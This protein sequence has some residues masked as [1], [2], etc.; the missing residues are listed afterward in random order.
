MT[1]KKLYLMILI[2][3]CASIKLSHA[4][5]SQSLNGGT[6]Q[7]MMSTAETIEAGF[8]TWFMNTRVD[9]FNSATTSG[10][11]AAQIKINLGYVVALGE[12]VEWGF[13]APIIHYTP[14]SLSATP[15][16]SGEGSIRTTFKYNFLKPTGINSSSKA[17][18][19]FSSLSPE[20]S[21]AE[22]SSKNDLYGI[23]YN[24]SHY[25]DGIA[26]HTNFGYKRDEVYSGTVITP[27][28]DANFIT[29]SI[30]L[31]RVL[32][33]ITTMSIQGLAEV[34]D[35][36]R[37]KNLLLS[38]S[39]LYSLSNNVALT[40]G[41]LIGVPDNRSNPNNSIFF[42]ISYS[43]GKES[44]PQKESY[45]YSI[46]SNPEQ[47]NVKRQEELIEKIST[48]EQRLANIEEWLTKQE[49]VSVRSDSLMSV[50]AHKDSSKTKESSLEAK[51]KRLNIEIIVPV[52]RP[53]YNDHIIS[54][55]KNDKY[56]FIQKKVKNLVNK[57]SYIF[58]RSGLRKEAISLGHSLDGNQTVLKKTLPKGVDLQI[59][60]GLDLLK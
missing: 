17:V 16:L 3:M 56:R 6:G 33:D 7:G 57:K 27:F 23:E 9:S 52:E 20:S 4:L 59:F 18:T 45:L 1:M 2:V 15:S 54:F 41:A 25:F 32:S 46:S 39:F 8:S 34:N 13:S 31:E 42:G 55:I 38:T 22:V 5:E 44:K 35:E 19:L 51:N 37:D 36:T 50:T 47:L 48:V 58:Y 26:L 53:S 11:N 12:S 49:A 10:D 43:P 28:V 21:N 14:D 29:A 24:V 40:I 60:L 30:G